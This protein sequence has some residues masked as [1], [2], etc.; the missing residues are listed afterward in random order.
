MAAAF[1]LC[2]EGRARV[3]CLHALS[4]S[5]WLLLA[6]VCKDGVEDIHLP[7]PGLIFSL[8]RSPCGSLPPS[9]V[10]LLF[11]ERASSS[12]GE[13]PLWLVPLPEG[14]ER[15]PALYA[16][17]FVRVPSSAPAPFSLSLSLSFYNAFFLFYLFFCARA[18]TYS[19]GRVVFFA[20][21]FS[22]F[23]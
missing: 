16:F 2:I 8:T 20:G 15:A 19:L 21:F 4:S 13:V 1:A 22:G 12:R 18:H 17:L 7:S 10:L 3:S 9:R 23:V 14:T 6:R 5:R 11:R